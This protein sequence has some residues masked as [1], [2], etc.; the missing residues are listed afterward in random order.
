MVR[1]ADRF[2]E[3]THDEHLRHAAFVGLRT[4]KPA[5]DVRREFS[6]DTAPR[7]SRELVS[8]A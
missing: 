1:G 5:R 2:V 8:R 4:D 3:W 7:L 6:A